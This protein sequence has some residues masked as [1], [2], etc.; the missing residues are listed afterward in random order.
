MDG[1][2]P[3][4]PEP[5]NNWH[6]RQQIINA[7]WNKRKKKYIIKGIDDFGDKYE[8]DWDTWQKEANAKFA[9]GNNERVLEPHHAAWETAGGPDATV[10]YMKQLF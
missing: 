5:E 7:R 4:V 3:S 6:V 10:P 1:S 8:R 9:L 2:G